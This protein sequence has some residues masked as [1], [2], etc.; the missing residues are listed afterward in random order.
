RKRLPATNM[1]SR[2]VRSIHSQFSSAGT[3]GQSREAS[4]AHVTLAGSRRRPRTRH[5]RLRLPAKQIQASFR[6]ALAETQE[7]YEDDRADG[8]GDQTPDEPD[9]L[10][11]QQTEQEPAEQGADDADDQVADKSI[12]AALHDLPGEPAGRDAD[13]DEP[14]KVH[15]PPPFFT[16]FP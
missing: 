1:P 5:G 13:Q 12:A 6:P 2:K 11:T 7:E 16:S 4:R 9:R 15:E 3:R 10:Q 14:H 8:G